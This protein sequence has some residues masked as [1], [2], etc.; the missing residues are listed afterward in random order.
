VVL[1][2]VDIGCGESGDSC[3]HILSGAA[4]RVVHNAGPKTIATMTSLED[5]NTNNN[6]NSNSTAPMTAPRISEAAASLESLR[7]VSFNVAGCVPSKEAPASWD[8][9]V[10]A[11]AMAEEVLRSDPDILALQESPSGDPAKLLQAFPSYQVMGSTAA[12]ADYVVLLVKKGISATLV[13]T[14]NGDVRIPAVL[15]ETATC[16]W[17]ASIW[18]PFV[19]DRRYDRCRWRLSWSMP[20]P[21]ICPSSLPGIPI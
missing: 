16:W 3:F 11:E 17:P 6:N 1:H 14:E 5:N 4:P 18:L 9:V 2:S 7:L 15:V 12:H 10:A 21:R 8:S 19:K 20:R 13:P